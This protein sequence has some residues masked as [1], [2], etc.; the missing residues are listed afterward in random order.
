[1]AEQKPL[2]IPQ[3][4]EIMYNRGEKEK[5]EEL[6]AYKPHD[7]KTGRMP[8]CSPS[9]SLVSLPVKQHV[10]GYEASFHR[11]LRNIASIH[12]PIISSSVQMSLEAEFLHFTA[13]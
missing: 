6:E 9:T 11:V 5:L 8:P 3:R 4:K 1:M 10:T 7:L 2:G 13:N 12:I